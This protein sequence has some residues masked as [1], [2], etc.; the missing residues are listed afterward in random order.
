MQ[1][2][3]QPRALVDTNNKPTKGQKSNMTQNLVARYPSIISQSVPDG[4]TPELVVL[5]GMFLVH[6][7]PFGTNNTFKDYSMLLLRRFVQP[8]FKGGANKLHVIF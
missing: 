3:E 7:K 6:V 2:I 8:H 4:W 1:F 5:D